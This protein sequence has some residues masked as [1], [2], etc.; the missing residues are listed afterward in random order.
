MRI[1]EVIACD[2]RVIAVRISLLGTSPELA[3]GEVE[4]SFV[5]VRVYEGGVFVSSEMFDADDRQAILAR[6][7][8]L[9][10]LSG[11]E[12]VLR[13]YLQTLERRD[14]H[15]LPE[16]L[17][18]DVAVRD[19]RALAG[20]QGRGVEAAL[21]LAQSALGVTSELRFEFEEII[22]ADDSALACRGSWIGRAADGAGEVVL[23]MG[24]VVAVRRDRIAA[25]ELYEHTDVDAMRE[26]FDGLS[27]RGDVDPAD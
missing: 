4:V 12:A 17:D 18:P 13:R 21:E 9:T 15:H 19:H 14:L 11:P 8:E 5:Q 6:Y 3:G 27:C 1:D 24:I 22:A 2:E 25:L 26:R 20:P 7:A 16:M 10:R 23:P